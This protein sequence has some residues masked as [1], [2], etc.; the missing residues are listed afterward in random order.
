MFISF[1]TRSVAA[2]ACSV[3]LVTSVSAAIVD[4]YSVGSGDKSAIIQ[5]DFTTEKAIVFL[6]AYY[7]VYLRMNNLKHLTADQYMSTPHILRDT[8][9]YFGVDPAEY[10]TLLMNDSHGVSTL[11]PRVRVVPTQSPQNIAKLMA[12]LGRRPQTQYHANIPR[13]SPYTSIMGRG[14][15]RRTK[16]RRVVKRRTRKHKKN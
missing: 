15:K 5:I 2:L 6:S 8:L 11:Q 12:A 7:P 13:D 10:R 1:A 3:V 16:K 9:T 14:G 4:T